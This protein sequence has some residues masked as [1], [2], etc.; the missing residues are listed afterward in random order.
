LR[1]PVSSHNRRVR[2]H[3]TKAGLHESFQH[4]PYVSVE[5]LLP[6]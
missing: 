4:A 3:I 6:L 5:L 2:L 1:K